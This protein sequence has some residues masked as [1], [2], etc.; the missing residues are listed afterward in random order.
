ME[1]I[2]ISALKNIGLDE[3]RNKILILFTMGTVRLQRAY[4][5]QERGI[6]NFFQNRRTL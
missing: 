3:L 1:G 2:K 4:L 5:L 6:E